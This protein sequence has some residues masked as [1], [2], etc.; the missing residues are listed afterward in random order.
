MMTEADRQEWIQT[1]SGGRF[2]PLNPRPQDVRLDDIAHALANICRYTGHCSQFY[3]VAQHSV[4]VSLA[5]APGHALWALLHDAS[6]AYLVDVPRPL[7][8]HP[9]F[10]AYR[11]AEA[12]VERCIAVAFGLCWPIPEETKNEV[13]YAD[14]VL[15]ATE[16]RDFMPRREIYAWSWMPEPMPHRLTSWSPDRAE[17]TFLQAAA[18]LGLEPLLGDALAKDQDRIAQVQVETQ[19]QA[20]QERAAS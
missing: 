17:H 6:E 2:Y 5:V 18:D 7:K 16:A 14:L 3:S 13:K 9:S 12:E 1:A 15:L 8:Q 20:N 19:A 4:L 10:D 11:D